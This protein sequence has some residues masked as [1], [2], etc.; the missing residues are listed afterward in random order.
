M[1]N[2]TQTRDLVV[3][4]SDIVAL[5]LLERFNNNPLSKPINVFNPLIA[6]ALVQVLW[7]RAYISHNLLHLLHQSFLPFSFCRANAKKDHNHS[8]KNNRNHLQQHFFFL[9]PITGMS[10]PKGP[11]QNAPL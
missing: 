7:D 6:A 10:A 11:Q 1:Q 4:S 5:V 3:N 9:F 2:P 8:R